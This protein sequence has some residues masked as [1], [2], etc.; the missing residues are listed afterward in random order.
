MEDELIER[1][2]EREDLGDLCSSFWR[3]NANFADVSFR[4]SNAEILFSQC[5]IAEWP[6]N[7]K[8]NCQLA[9]WLHYRITGSPE[10]RF[11]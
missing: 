10:F 1:E 4:S 3:L 7:C 8:G 2:R 11:A 5:Q 9:P 6:D